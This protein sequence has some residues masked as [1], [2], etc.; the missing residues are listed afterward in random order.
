MYWYIK[1]ISTFHHKGDNKCY[2]T[3]AYYSAK[4]PICYKCKYALGAKVDGKFSNTDTNGTNKEFTDGQTRIH[5]MVIICCLILEL[6][7]GLA[8]NILAE[9]STRTTNFLQNDADNFRKY[10][11]ILKD[12]AGVEYKVGPICAM[13]ELF[14]V[15]TDCWKTSP[16]SPLP[17]NVIP[18]CECEFMSLEIAAKHIINNI[19]SLKRN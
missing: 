12:A 15:G 13:L 5:N 11:T 14:S 8:E 1:N 17:A 9:L 19:K 6:H 4:D 3:T 7:K 2:N 10:I 18:L 16:G